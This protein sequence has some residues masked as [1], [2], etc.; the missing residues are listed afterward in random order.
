MWGTK[1]N[2]WGSLQDVNQTNLQNTMSLSAS[3]VLVTWR[4]SYLSHSQPSLNFAFFLK[5]LPFSLICLSLFRSSKLLYWP[6]FQPWHLFP[7]HSLS[8]FFFSQNFLH[9]ICCPSDW[10]L[11]SCTGTA[12]ENFFS[13]LFG[14]YF[15]APLVYKIY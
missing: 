7:V 14:L 2:I 11:E 8:L 1:K 13:L 6:L 3:Q 5:L 10:K 9:F 4:S 12:L 15:L